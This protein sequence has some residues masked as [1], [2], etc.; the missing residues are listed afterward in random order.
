M[1]TLSHRFVSHSRKLFRFS[2]NPP[3]RFSPPP[4][5]VSLSLPFS[6]HPLGIPRHCLESVKKVH[7][8]VLSILLID[9]PSTVRW[10]TVHSS[11]RVCT[12]CSSSTHPGAIQCQRLREV[13][14][15]GLL[16]SIAFTVLVD[17]HRKLMGA[18]VMSIRRQEIQ[19]T[20]R[21]SW[22]ATRKVRIEPRRER[23]E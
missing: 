13:V 18:G 20:Q 5:T 23:I 19:H 16:G 9:F 22:E 6:T 8:L 21:K 4:I 15:H 7:I 17:A 1:S 11:I 10:R 2:F 12:A 14:V 3:L